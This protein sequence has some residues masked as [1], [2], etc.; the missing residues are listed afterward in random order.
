MVIQKLKIIVSIFFLSS[1]V[2]MSVFAQNEKVYNLS[3]KDET[4]EEIGQYFDVKIDSIYITSDTTLNFQ[5]IPKIEIQDSVLKQK[6]STFL[7]MLIRNTDADIDKR[8]KD[9]TFDFGNYKYEGLDYTDRFKTIG[10]EINTLTF[11]N[12]INENGNATISVDYSYRDDSNISITAS[13]SSGNPLKGILYKKSYALNTEE[14]TQDIRLAFLKTLFL[15]N[16]VDENLLDT[17]SNFTI[18]AINLI[19]IITSLQNET[20]LNI[21]MNEENWSPVSIAKVNVDTFYVEQTIELFGSDSFDPDGN[22]VNY[23]WHQLHGDSLTLD[24][25]TENEGILT[26][27][28]LANAHFVAEWPGLYRYQLTIEDNEGLQN[29]SFVDVLVTNRFQKEVKYKAINLLD[30]KENDI[31]SLEDATINKIYS[32]IGVFYVEFVNTFYYLQVE[33]LPVIDRMIG[34]PYQQITDEF[35]INFIN[36]AKE[37]G[38]SIIYSHGIYPAPNVPF[39]TNELKSQE[40]WNTWFDQFEPLIL[41]QA[42]IAQQLNVEILNIYYVD[43]ANLFD[44]RNSILTRFKELLSKIRNKYSGLIG[45]GSAMGGSYNNLFNVCQYQEILNDENIDVIIAEYGVKLFEKAEP[46]LTIN[47]IEERIKM[48]LITKGNGGESFIEIAN[49]ISK[50]FIFHFSWNSAKRQNEFEFFEP[51]DPIALDNPHVK[52]DFYDQVRMYEGTIQAV[53]DPQISQYIDG[54]II[55]GYFWNDMFDTFYPPNGSIVNTS[56]DRAPNIRNKPAEKLIRLWFN[57]LKN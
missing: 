19:K 14:L 11:I 44:S 40:W 41:H 57:I 26:D 13:D 31:S 20:D 50:P 28:T 43:L 5:L 47:D 39:P 48:S 7:E 36:K 6:Y 46:T 56:G 22:I 45:I 42:E 37:K 34:H 38:F 16:N 30:S 4:G 21:Y 1:L 52:L 27:S 24:Y 3:I 55:H 17:D 25:M 53:L 12:I 15:N 54:I 18:D 35:I 49:R 8:W 32:D 23:S 51:A 2:I 33:P 9:L 29:S 10:N